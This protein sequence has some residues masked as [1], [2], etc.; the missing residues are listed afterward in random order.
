MSGFLVGADPGEE[1]VL[2]FDEAGGFECR[3]DAVVGIEGH[4]LVDSSVEV[5]GGDL[6]EFTDG[7][8]DSDS[9]GELGFGLDG[10][11]HV[12]TTVQG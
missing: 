1:E 12:A 2:L 4:V 8:G 3:D 5:T 6:F 10:I 11:A 7:F 9:S